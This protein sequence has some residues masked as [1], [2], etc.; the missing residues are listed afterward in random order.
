MDGLALPPTPFCKTRG[1]GFLLGTVLSHRVAVGGG[2]LLGDAKPWIWIFVEVLTVWVPVIMSY[3]V[4][5]SMS[6]L[7]EDPTTVVPTQYNKS[8]GAAAESLGMS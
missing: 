3:H 8:P 5:H 4:K 2:P 1:Q 6:P 7:V